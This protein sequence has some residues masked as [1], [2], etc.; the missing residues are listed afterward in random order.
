MRIGLDLDNTLACHDATF[1]RLAWLA[2]RG[3]ET[4]ERVGGRQEQPALPCFE[5]PSIGRAQN[6]PP[7]SG[8][9]PGSLCN[10]E[11][12]LRPRPLARRLR[13]GLDR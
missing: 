12:V 6:P 13:A 10:R 2:E 3:W 4:F 7:N 1:G 9:L 5:N 8:R 11:G